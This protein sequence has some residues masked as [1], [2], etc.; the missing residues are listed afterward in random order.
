MENLTLPLSEINLREHWNREKIG[1]ISGLVQSIK[2]EGQLVPINVSLDAET[3]KYYLVDG[4]RRY[5]ALKEAGIDTAL[6]VITEIADEADYREKAL[7]VNLARKDNAPMEIAKEYL[8]LKAEAKR[9]VKDL[10]AKFGVTVG[11]I[12]QYLALM[13]LPEDI[14]KYVA[15]D[16]INF[17]QA[18]NLC[19]LDAENPKHVR[20]MNRLV[21]AI[22][23]DGAN[24]YWVEEAT[25]RF[26]DKMKSVEDGAKGKEK[27]DNKKKAPRAP[28][29][30]DYTDASV[31]KMM[32]PETAKESYVQA[33]VYGETYRAKA[34]SPKRRAYFEGWIAACKHNCKLEV[35]E[36]PDLSK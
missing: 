2:N 31:K 24:P 26:L 5:T 28:K 13:S 9:S 14:Q 35:V 19:R 17:S 22:V 34:Q 36:L 33:L 1:D 15:Q 18:R 20:A 12:N 32:K 3:G 27:G 23:K 21:D 11:S 16:K 6:V 29:F 25:T 7:V 4:R 10:A 8:F 30:V